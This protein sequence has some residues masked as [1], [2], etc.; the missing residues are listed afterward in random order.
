[1]KI[2]VIKNCLGAVIGAV[3]REKWGEYCDFIA[4]ED[5]VSVFLSGQDGEIERYSGQE[6]KRFYGDEHENN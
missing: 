3:E 2:A 6:F 4:D 5:T 1:M